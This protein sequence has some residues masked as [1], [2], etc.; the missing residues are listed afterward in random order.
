MRFGHS[1][2]DKLV[3]VN[4][5]FPFVSVIKSDSPSDTCFFTKQKRLPFLS[6]HIYA[7][8]FDLIHMDIWGPLSIPSMF[9]YRYYLL[10]LMLEDS[11]GFIS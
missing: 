10:L 2:L 8:H 11:I 3:E 4:K 7:H 1:S 6:S 5:M 9:G